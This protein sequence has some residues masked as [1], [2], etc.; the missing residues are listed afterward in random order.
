MG[1]VSGTVLTALPELYSV[2][3][4]DVLVS[5]WMYR[6]GN[7]DGTEWACWSLGSSPS[8]LY[9]VTGP[10]DG[11]DMLRVYM[12]SGAAGGRTATPLNAWF[13]FF[14]VF[15]RTFTQ[16]SASGWMG[17]Y[18]NGIWQASTGMG[19]Y[20]AGSNHRTTVRINQ[21]L[22]IA[23]MSLWTGVFGS[24]TASY[25]SALQNALINGE[26]PMALSAFRRNLA[27]YL[28]LD[29]RRLALSPAKGIAQGFEETLVRYTGMIP[30][31][32]AY[33]HRR[34]WN[35]GKVPDAYWQRRPS[36]LF[37]PGRA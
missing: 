30:P 13:H 8:V 35:F 15:S 6:Y 37:T 33:Q 21:S 7:F 16:W 25:W 10:S 29:T 9:V 11:A 27:L 19:T 32:E 23:E 26:N 2:A 3:D 18:Y 24:A 34:M 28:P 4:S 20:P 5:M 12:S 22:V 31:C 1:L 17:H 36:G 14:G